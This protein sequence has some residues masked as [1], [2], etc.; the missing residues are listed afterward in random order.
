MYVMAM[1]YE[2]FMTQVELPTAN[3]MTCI[4][5]TAPLNTQLFL[6]GHSSY[7]VWKEVEN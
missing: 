6:C 5:E 3:I 7:P 1:D 4:V 2:E